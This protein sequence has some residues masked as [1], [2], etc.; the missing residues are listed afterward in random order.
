MSKYFDIEGNEYEIVNR[1]PTE[2][3]R[4]RAKES[5]EKEKE[6][7]DYNPFDHP[8]KRVLLNDEHKYL[9]CYREFYHD[10]DENGNPVE[11]SLIQWYTKNGDYVGAYFY[12]SLINFII[13]NEIQCDYKQDGDTICSIGYSEK[14]KTWYGWGHRGICGIKVG[15]VIDSRCHLAYMPDNVDDLLKMLKGFE[16]EGDNFYFEKLNDTTV[17]QKVKVVKLVGLS[18]TEAI[19]K[20]EWDSALEY[21]IGLGL[22]K[23]ET[24]EEAKQA[25]IIAA[26]NLN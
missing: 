13:K 1:E 21:K 8:F 25:A 6:F 26:R 4:K 15:D 23:I 5:L 9:N 3:E 19:M 17:V 10:R 16:L 24:L 20:S 11:S 7:M 22:K 14:N 18:D 12:R 2:E